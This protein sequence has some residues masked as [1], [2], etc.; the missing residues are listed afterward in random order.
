M[1]SY[2]KLIA[3]TCALF[4]C[5]SYGAAAETYCRSTKGT[6][7]ILTNDPRNGK[8]IVVD[9]VIY[10]FKVESIIGNKKISTYRDDSG[11]LANVILIVDPRTGNGDIYIVIYLDSSVRRDLDIDKLNLHCEI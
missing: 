6:W 1:K 3:L 7:H 11:T 10:R 5:F 8:N 2:I 4:S 9:G